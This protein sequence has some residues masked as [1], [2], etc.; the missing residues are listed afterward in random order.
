MNR[1]VAELDIENLVDFFQ[2]KIRLPDGTKLN[3]ALYPGSA[4]LDIQAIVNILAAYQIVTF[5]GWNYDLPILVLA[6]HGAN[7]EQLKAAGDDI[8]VRQMKPWDFYRKYGFEIP[9]YIDHV[10]LFDVAPGVSIG[11][12]MY[13]GRIHAPKMQDLPV[14]F[15]VP[16]EPGQRLGISTYCDN[17][18]DG[19][20]LLRQGLKDRLALRVA[21]SDQYQID[22][23]S[24]SDAQIAEAVIK[25]TLGFKPERRYIRHGFEFKYEAPAYINFVSPQLKRLLTAVQN[26]PF[27]VSDKE[28]AQ[29]LGHEEVTRTGVQIPEELKGRDIRIGSAIYRMGIGGLHSQESSV[30]YRTI[31][32]VQTLEDIDVKSYYPSLI[33]GMDMYPQQ[34]GSRF[35]EIYRAIYTR[36]LTA[37]SEASKLYDLG[38]LSEAAD[39]QTESDGLK[40]VLN[41]TFGKLF[42]KYS[43]LYAP[44]FG[45]RTTVTGQ[46]ALLMLIEMMELSGIQ[47]VSANTDGI[48]LLIPH[49]LRPIAQ[50]NVAWWERT[51]GLEMESTRYSGIYMRDVNNYIA[52]TMDGKAKRKGVFAQ[53]G[54][55]SGPQGKHPDKD[56]CGDAVVALLAHGVPLERT[57][58]DCT[59]IRKFIQVRA[60]KGGAVYS[61]TGE[62]LGKAVRWYHGHTQGYIAYASNGNKV[63]GS[64]Y[65]IPAMT[66]PTSLP[67]DINHQHYI[68]V[69]NEMLTDIGLKPC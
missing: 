38:L 46:L 49:G 35:I 14:A 69:A 63:A 37:K 59:D 61:V 68:D 43:I 40:I 16:I 25:A 15:D 67:S 26:A 33:L 19:T 13:M 58:Q 62:Y 42:S 54:L 24:K 28:E 60:A 30:N 65:A 50:S 36:R 64:D 53:G 47:V 56:I 20:H 34:L 41:G 17:D 44:E 22:V 31:P 9:S 11:L 23:R 12:K 32:G 10:D 4:P 52:L 55:L 3:F 5:N 51:T 8:I 6:L 2:I 39:L 45:I 27:V 18:L 57:I 29:S 21:I 48:V 1:P 66:L 7:N